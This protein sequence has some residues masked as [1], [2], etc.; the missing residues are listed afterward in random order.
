[1]ISECIDIFYK[2]KF[3]STEVIVKGTYNRIKNEIQQAWGFD[4]KYL[5]L[6]CYNYQEYMDFIKPGKDIK[7]F[8]GFKTMNVSDTETKTLRC[9]YIK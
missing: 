4:Q 6:A 1:M 7:V 2:D 8:K 9:L 5:E 3:I